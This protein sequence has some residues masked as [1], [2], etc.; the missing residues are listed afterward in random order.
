MLTID[1]A[2][3]LRDHA[4]GDR[5]GAVEEAGEV[6]LDRAPPRLDTLVEDAARLVIRTGVVDEDVDPVSDVAEDPSAGGGIRDVELHRLAADVTGH[7]LCTVGVDVGHDH[8]RTGPGERARDALA[9]TGGGPGHHGGPAREIQQLGDRRVHAVIVRMDA[10]PPRVGRRTA[11]PLLSCRPA[12][13]PNPGGP[14]PFPADRDASR[15]DPQGIR[16]T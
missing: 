11:A 7:P 15:H 8:V 4:S 12:L 3:A 10:S 9:D 1:S 2:V 16:E 14:C 5:F 6:E 13:A